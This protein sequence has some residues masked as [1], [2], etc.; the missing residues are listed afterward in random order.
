MGGCCGRN[1]SDEEIDKATSLKELAEI[2]TKR[3][4]TFP[5]EGDQI[6]AYLQ[7]PNSEVENIDV[8]GIEPSI[9]EKRIDYLKD[10]EGA[11]TKV[12]ETLLNNPNLPLDECK[13]HCT[14]IVSRYFQTYDP[15]KELDSDMEKFDQFVEKNQK[16]E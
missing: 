7:D 9:L 16:K 1:F 8:K 10:L 4:E 5:S 11:Y 3:K 14:D 6:A 12:A 2:L 15:N 13:S